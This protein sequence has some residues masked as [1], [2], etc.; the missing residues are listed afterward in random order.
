M[1]RSTRGSRFGGVHDSGL[2]TCGEWS[3]I[4]SLTQ[5]LTRSQGLNIQLNTVINDSSAAFISRA[6]SD[7][8]IRMAIILGTGMN[9]A[10]QLPITSFHPS[11]LNRPSIPK[12]HKY[13]QVLVNTELSMFGKTTFPV[14]RWDDCLNGSHQLPNYQ[15]FEYLVTGA[16]MSELVRLIIVEATRMAGL[17][18]GSLPKSLE[19]PY[20]LDTRTIAALEIDSSP[21]LVAARAQLQTLHPCVRTPTYSDLNFI[22]RIA[23][24]VSHRSSAYF[25]A[26]VH[27]L[28]SVT[29]DT[30]GAG[31]SSGHISIA[32]EGS[33]INNYPHYFERCQAVLDGMI[34]KVGFGRRKV[35]LIRSNESAIT[36]AGIAAAMATVHDQ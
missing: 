24:A 13:R 3:L 34:E 9:A 5:I 16:Y 14:T 27:A 28:C 6:Y 36:G 12:S 23:R 18:S 1:L 11:K 25:I 29:F 31:S 30:Q 35:T 2:S 8:S 4:P 10:V 19:R 33:I 22:Q 32:C 26:G 7:P 21:S 17:F 20:S 15:P